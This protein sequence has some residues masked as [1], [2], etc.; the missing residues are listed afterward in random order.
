MGTVIKTRTDD[1]N[2]FRWSLITD[3]FE[4][5]GEA[6]TLI[7]RVTELDDGVS[8]TLDYENG[9]IVRRFEQDNS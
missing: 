8:V 4:T 7:K 1:L 3:T 9:K 2:K 6:K 5:L